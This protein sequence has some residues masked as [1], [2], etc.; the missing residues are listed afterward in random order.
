MGFLKCARVF[1]CVCTIWH[2]QESNEVIESLG[3]RVTGS[4]EP[5]GGCWEPSPHPLKD[6][7]PLSHLCSHLEMG[8][9]KG[10]IKLIEVMKACHYDWYDEKEFGHRH[11]RWGESVKTQVRQ[12]CTRGDVW[13]ALC[14]RSSP[15][16]TPQSPVLW[17]S[18]PVVE[19]IQCVY[20]MQTAH[21]GTL[22]TECAREHG[23]LVTRQPSLFIELR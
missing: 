17:G 18:K 8:S 6:S 22:R 10:E 15:L 1:G 23:E 19:A 12:S 3:T 21:R 16:W 5:P 4:A 7:Y 11:I 20:L 13:T 14:S 2:S 9:S